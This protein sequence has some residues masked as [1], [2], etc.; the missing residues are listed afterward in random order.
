M[1]KKR[2]VHPVL[3]TA[4]ILI[5]T[6]A[7]VGILT[8]GW[9]LL[10]TAGQIKKTEKITDDDYD[11]ILVL[12]AGVWKN[13]P[14]PMLEDRIITGVNVHNNTGATLLM[15][16]DN[17]DDSYNE[18]GAMAD[19]AEKMGVDPADIV[20]DR[21]G[22]STYDSLWRARNLYGAKKIVIITQRYH[23]HRA[24]YIARSLGMEAKGVSA[25]RRLYGSK[26]IKYTVREWLA[27]N[28][29]FWYSIIK[30]EPEHLEK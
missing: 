15:S 1:K 30:P 29:D 6:L 24:L 5:F 27:R 10:S 19:Y 25:N 8:S 26:M 13:G 14:S 12:G 11:C 2:R 20:Q 17:Q 28:K 7:A 9:V 21:Y 4:V 18:P 23:L 22:L 3:R 16:G